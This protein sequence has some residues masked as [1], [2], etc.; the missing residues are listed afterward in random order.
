MR[1]D[2]L[3]MAE[4]NEIAKENQ[5]L[6]DQYEALVKEIDE[7]SVLMEKQ[8]EEKEKTSSTIEDEMLT[9]ISANEEE[10]KK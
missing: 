3:R 2:A 10:I 1:E 7:K 8:I 6:K 9:K 5:Q 4:N